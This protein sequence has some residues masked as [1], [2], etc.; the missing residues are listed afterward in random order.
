MQTFFHKKKR[1]T[2]K[3]TILFRFSYQISTN[4][5][6]LTTLKTSFIYMDY[7]IKTEALDFNHAWRNKIGHWT[8]DI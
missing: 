2:L 6:A 7:L 5:T 3:K 1:H 8:G 4:L